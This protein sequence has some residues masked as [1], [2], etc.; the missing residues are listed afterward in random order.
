MEE[1]PW[2][3]VLSGRDHRDGDEE[4]TLDLEVD[5]VFFAHWVILGG[6]EVMERVMRET[7]EGWRTAGKFDGALGGGSMSFLM[8]W[9]ARL[10]PDGN[11]R[12]LTN[13]HLLWS[14][15]LL[16]SWILQPNN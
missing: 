10:Q 7:A 16:P 5:C 14:A 15:L 12:R 13:D 1:C 8:L 6:K 4:G 2:Q 3:F 11:L 9:S